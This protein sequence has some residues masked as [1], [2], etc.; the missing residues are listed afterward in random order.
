[1]LPNHQFLFSLAHYIVSELSSSSIVATYLAELTLS[2]NI[3]HD[4]FQTTLYMSLSVPTS[5][6]V[7][8][9]A[10]NNLPEMDAF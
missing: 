3:F 1:M 4:K 6:A 9:L 8:Y 5:S 2:H 7:D 10:S